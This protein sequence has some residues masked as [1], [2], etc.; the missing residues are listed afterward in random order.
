[1]DKPFLVILPVLYRL[2]ALDDFTSSLQLQLQL[3][4]LTD[5]CA[6]VAYLLKFISTR[7]SFVTCLPLVFAR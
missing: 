4:L 1:M 5:I 7:E 2:T 6:F 3:Q